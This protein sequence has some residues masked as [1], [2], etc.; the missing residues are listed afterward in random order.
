MRRTTA[1]ALSSLVLT[2]GGVGVVAA[3]PLEL[4]RH[5]NPATPDLI[6]PGG[7]ET[8]ARERP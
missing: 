6:G 3:E 7:A 5:H 2:F 8:P 1:V 4:R